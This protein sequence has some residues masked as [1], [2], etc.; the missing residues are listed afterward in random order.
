M[1]AGVVSAILIYNHMIVIFTCSQDMRIR[2]RKRRFT[3]YRRAEHDD[4]RPERLTRE[5]RAWLDMAAVG[6]EFGSK[7]FDVESR[8]LRTPADHA[9]ALKEL[10]TLMSAESGTSEGQRLLV[11]A[12]LIQ[13][14][15]AKHF[16]MDVAKSEDDCSACRQSS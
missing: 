3:Q 13:E 4:V 10:D 11:L 1:A 9:V 6:G 14:Y 5:D 15:E 16:P 7:D 2:V 12:N 8:P